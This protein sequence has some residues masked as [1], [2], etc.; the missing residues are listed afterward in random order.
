MGIAGTEVAK[1]ASSIILMD[2]NFSSIVKAVSWGRTINDA[3]KKFLQFQLTVNF[4]AVSIAFISSIYSENNLSVLNAVQL[5]WINLIM[6]SLAALALATDPPNKK[7]LERLPESKAASL[8]SP[9]M[10]KMIVGQGIYQITISLVLFIHGASLFRLNPNDP[11]DQRSLNSFIFNTFTFL[12]LFNLCNLY[13][14]NKVNCR[15][16]TRDWKI[17][18]GIGNNSIF[19]LILLSIIVVQI[20][21]VEFGGEVFKTTPISPAMWAVGIFISMVSLLLGIIVRLLP[22]C[23]ENKE[24]ATKNTP[25]ILEYSRGLEAQDSV[26]ESLRKSRALNT[27]ISYTSLSVN[28]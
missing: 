15:S 22:D 10:W 1:E 8:I 28:K 5:L 25:S 16:I 3:V 26:V 7:I 11:H 17:Y 18:R 12:Q 21:I 6:D 14:F 2:D 20:L 13:N 23:W 9:P 24:K 27:G 4:S 19:P